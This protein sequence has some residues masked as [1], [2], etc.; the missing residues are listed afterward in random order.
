MTLDA[1]D[2]E[3]YTLEVVNDDLTGREDGDDTNLDELTACDCAKLMK[4]ENPF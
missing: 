4:H 1:I 3:G 2:E